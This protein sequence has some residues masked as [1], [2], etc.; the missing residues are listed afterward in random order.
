VSTLVEVLNRV[1]RATEKAILETLG[2]RDP[3]LA[4]QIK[5]LMFVFEDIIHLDDRSVQQVLREVDTKELSLALKGVNEEVSGKVFR[6]M[7]K[8]AA[9]M[10]QEEMEFMGPVRLKDVEAA[11]QRIVNVIRQLE[12][13]GEI[14][15]ARGGEEEVIV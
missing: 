10:L 11:Q 14:I 3:E 12:D 15:I 2:D 8:R 7:S 9:S 6:N 4:D 13:A 1:D 5:N